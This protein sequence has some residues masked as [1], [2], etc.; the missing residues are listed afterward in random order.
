MAKSK[1]TRRET[2]KAPLKTFAQKRQAKHEKKIKSHS[3]WTPA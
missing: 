1:D 2:K 3:G